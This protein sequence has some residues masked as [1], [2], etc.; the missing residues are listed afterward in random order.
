[1]SEHCICSGMPSLKNTH[2]KQRNIDLDIVGIGE[3]KGIVILEN[4]NCIASFDIVYCP[5]CGEKLYKEDKPK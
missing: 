3:D 4:H 1:M 2:Y 5:I